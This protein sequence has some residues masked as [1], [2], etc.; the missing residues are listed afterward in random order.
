VPKKKKEERGTRT[1]KRKYEQR[2]NGKDR[3]ANL[4]S[5]KQQRTLKRS[6]TQTTYKDVIV[7]TFRARIKPKEE[8]KCCGAG[9]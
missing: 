3:R 6:L 2:L 7:M 5:E 8:K 1:D 9:G 4:N